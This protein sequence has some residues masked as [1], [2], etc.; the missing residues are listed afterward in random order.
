MKLGGHPPEA[1]AP[2]TAKSRLLWAIS[3]PVIRGTAVAVFSLK[4]VQQG[5][6]PPPPFVIAANHYSHFDPPLI[7]SVLRRPIRFLAVDGLLGTSRVLDWL[8]D[9][10]GAI[11]TPRSRLPIA[12]VRTALDA[13]HAGEV[14]AV[15]PEGTRVSHWGTLPPK[16]GAAWLAVRAGVPMV[17]IALVG[18]GKAMG[19]ENRIRRSAVK[20]VIGEPM[21][22]DVGPTLLM[23]RWADWMTTQIS[24]HPDSEVE[25]DRRAYFDG[26]L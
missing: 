3:P 4:V 16:R 11:P 18:T 17:P 26:A 25:G 2:L 12:A 10:Y 21:D 14:V 6:L 13:L 5:V 22:P 7:G 15:F 9:G 24:A 20:V 1:R 23:Q 8:V 19:L